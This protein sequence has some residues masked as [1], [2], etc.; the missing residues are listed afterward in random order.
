MLHD[1]LQFGLHWILHEI[2]LLLHANYN[3]KIHDILHNIFHVTLQCLHDLICIDLICSICIIMTCILHRIQ[4]FYL[5]ITCKIYVLYII[6][7][8]FVHQNIPWRILGPF[9]GPWIDEIEAASIPFSWWGVCLASREA[10]SLS[11][12]HV[13]WYCSCVACPHQG[14]LPRIDVIG[15]TYHQWYII[16]THLN[17]HRLG[18]D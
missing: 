6:F 18:V 9:H 15:I 13:V 5:I 10:L 1:W 12:S 4:G 14:S 16:N 11:A 8:S 17:R 2:I 7:T 3:L